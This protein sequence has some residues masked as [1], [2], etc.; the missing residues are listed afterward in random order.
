[1]FRACGVE[2]DITVTE[3]RGHAHELA[4][5]AAAA[6]EPLVVAWGGDGT[7]NE[8]GSALALRKGTAMA[9]VPAGSGNGFARALGVSLNPREAIASLLAGR[10]IAVDAGELDGRLFFNVA[11]AG[12]DAEIAR[13]FNQ[14]AH[15]RRGLA[16]YVVA[17]LKCLLSYE[18]RRYEIESA[19]GTTVRE[20][21]LL[22]FANARQYGNGAQIA[23]TAR[24]NDGMIDIVAVGNRALPVNVWRIR[25]LFNGTIDRDRDVTMV[26]VARATVRSAVPLLFH[27]DGE[28]HQAGTELTL[29]ARTR[30]LMLRVPNLPVQSATIALY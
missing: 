30:S 1:M 28:V 14:R 25:R 8:V 19:E 4:T 16:P 13:I 22:A 10:D 17:T 6:G 7:V 26:R 2:A 20:A 15:G 5:A 23:P 3:W 27:V 21:V 24:I 9:V 11:G 18:P 12:I 29:R